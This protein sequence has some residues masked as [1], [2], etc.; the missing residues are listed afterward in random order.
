MNAGNNVSLMLA[1]QDNLQAY[2]RTRIGPFWQT[3]GIGIQILTMGLVFGL[4]FKADIVEYLPFLATSLILW[5]FISATISDGCTSFIAAEAMIK[6]L[7][8]PHI[9]YLLRVVIK[10]LILTAH[11]LLILPCVFLTFLISPKVTLV[12]FVPGL[13]LVMANLLWVVGLIA[14]ISARYRDFPPIVQSLLTI[15][16][17]VTPVM[18]YPKLLGDN[19]LA[20][21]LLGLNPLYHWLQI[22]RLPALGD[23]PTFENWAVATVTLFIGWG[24]TSMAYKR[25]KN[26]IAYWV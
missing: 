7:Q 5:G 10:N 9:Q 18:W 14:L 16:F 4:I 17:Y 13:L 23:W 20:H 21:L 25:H 15:A 11:H 22:V 3:I 1:W 8:I 19:D 24:V 26:M 6:Q 2:R 12:A